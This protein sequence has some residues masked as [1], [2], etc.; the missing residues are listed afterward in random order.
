MTPGQA[1]LVDELKAM[2]AGGDTERDHGRADDILCEY[3]RSLGADEV[4]DA[5]KAAQ[6]RCGFW[7]A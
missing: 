7:Y 5:W 3:L 6:D 4:V 1:Y 2:K